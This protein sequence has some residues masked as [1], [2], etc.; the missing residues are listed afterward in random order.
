MMSHDKGHVRVNTVVSLTHFTCITNFHVSTVLLIGVPGSLWKII[1]P[2]GHRIL[3]ETDLDLHLHSWHVTKHGARHRQW[4]KP[5]D[6]F[7]LYSHFNVLAI[8]I[9]SVLAKSHY[10]THYILYYHCIL[11]EGFAWRRCR[12]WSWYQYKVMQVFCSQ[13]PA[14]K[15]GHVSFEVISTVYIQFVDNIRGSKFPAPYV[16]YR[17]QEVHIVQF[18]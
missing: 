11:T 2:V 8:T 5:V 7:G 10:S 1:I 16:M 6:I 4:L 14:V 15:G 12:V 13:F 18:A 9:S 17:A 3:I